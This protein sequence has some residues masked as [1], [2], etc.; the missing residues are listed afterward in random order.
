MSIFIAAPSRWSFV[1]GR[2]SKPKYVQYPFHGQTKH[3]IEAGNASQTTIE[4]RLATSFLL[5]WRVY[6]QQAFRQ[7]HPDLPALQIELF[8]ECFGE[9][10]FVWQL[11]STPNH[12]QRRFSGPELHIFNLADLT[13]AVEH[14]ATDQVAQVRPPRFQLSALA[15]RKLKLGAHQRLG[16]GNRLDAL[17]LQHQKT[18]MRPE[19]LDRY[20]AALAVFCERPQPHFLP[21]AARS[22]GVQFDRYFSAASLRRD[23][24]RQANP[25]AACV[26][27]R[28][29]SPLYSIISSA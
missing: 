25:F 14:C 15:A 3:S 20:F 22:I 7:I 16:I 23:D 1:V 5:Y 26:R 9:G 18:L 11:R 24:D 21:E 27:C 10:D 19:I 2:L 28:R 4:H 13:L 12:Q 17:K 8:Q 29:H 6:F